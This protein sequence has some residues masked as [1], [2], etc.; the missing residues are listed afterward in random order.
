MDIIKKYYDNI[1]EIIQTVINKERDNIEE[2]AKQVAQTVF[3]DK[4][5]YVFGTGAHSIMAAMELFKRA[6]GLCNV[7][8][9]FPSGLTDFDGRPKTERITGFSS[10]IFNW[11]GVKSG[12]LLIICNV[13]GINPMTIDA[14]IEAKK[15]GIKTIGVTSIEFAEN[16]EPNI[17]NR[18]PSNK[19]LHD[20]VDLVIDAHVPVGDALLDVPGVSVKVGAGST[21]PMIFIVNSIVIRAIEI[22][23]QNGIEPPVL[24]SGNIAQGEQYN[25]KYWEK[26]KMR[27]RFF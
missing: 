3:D 21:Y 17:P 10:Q 16:V 23:A 1:N 7:Q 27:I 9:I 25:Q 13:N 8:G 24:L 14:A 20:L 6:G 5:F 11:Y 18:H 4:V 2:A 15:I 19:N 26:Y 22:V 12:D